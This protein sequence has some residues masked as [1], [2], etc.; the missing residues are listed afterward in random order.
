MAWL[1]ISI[2]VMVL[3]LAVAV[4]PV[5]WQSV[6]LHRHEHGTRPTAPLATPVKAHTV[7]AATLSAVGVDCPLCAAH[8]RAVTH[9]V[10]VDAV[11]RHAWRFHGIPSAQHITESARVA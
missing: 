9:D 4:V 10:L 1:F 2:P 3:A 5:V 8:I 7:G 6:R 11:E